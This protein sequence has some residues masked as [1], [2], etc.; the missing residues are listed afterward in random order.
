MVPFTWLA[1]GYSFQ[2]QYRPIL[3]V[4][5]CL[6]MFPSTTSPNPFFWRLQ[7][8]LWFMNIRCSPDFPLNLHGPPRL[9]RRVQRCLSVPGGDS[10]R[11]SP[12]GGVGSR[13]GIGLGDLPTIA[14]MILRVARW[15]CPIPLRTGPELQVSSIPINLRPIRYKHTR[16]NTPAFGLLMLI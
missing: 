1:G 6:L 3:I 11:F 10:C 13:G 16:I 2:C 14:A 5:V 9:L 15:G 4:C 7:N 12:P 8:T